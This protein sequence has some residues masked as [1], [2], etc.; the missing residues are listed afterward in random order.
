MPLDQE[1]LTYSPIHGW[2]DGPESRP[3]KVDKWSRALITIDNIKHNLWRGYN[4][5]VNASTLVDTGGKI[6]YFF[7]NNYSRPDFRFYFHAS[8]AA[9]YRGFLPATRTYVPANAVTPVNRNIKVLNEGTLTSAMSICHTPA[10]TGVTEIPFEKRYM[11]SVAGPGGTA[12]SGG[13]AE[14]TYLLDINGEGVFEIEARAD[15]CA[16]Y[17]E[18]SWTEFVPYD[19]PPLIVPIDN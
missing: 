8:T 19:T 3:I 6:S 1:K 5:I 12:Q 2:I 13:Q 15:D 18:F 14:G 4:F 16:I 17:A 7:A 11:G 9:I 10:T